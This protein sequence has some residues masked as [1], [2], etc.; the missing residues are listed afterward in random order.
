MDSR[1]LELLFEKGKQKGFQEQEIYYVRNKSTDISVYDGAIDKY[2][3]SE[4]SGLSYR[5]MLDGKLGYAYS[6]IIDE[7]AIEMLVLE[8][9]DNARVI[10]SDDEVFLF[11]G[12]E[13]YPEINHY[14]EQLSQS[15]ISEKI[16]FMLSLERELKAY[17]P[18]IKSISY[19]QYNESESFRRIKNTKGLDVTELSNICYA[20]AM[21]VVSDGVDTRTGLGYD[22]SNDFY[23]LSQAKI[24]KQAAEEAL[25]MLGA[26]TVKSKTCPVVIKNGT[27]AEFFSAFID[28]YNA[29]HVQKD[30]S[31]MAGR[32]GDQVSTSVLTVVDDP[33]LEMGLASSSFDAEGVATQKNTLIE[34]GVL[35]TFFHN[36]KTANKDGV[37]STGNASKASYKGTVGISPSNLIVKPG[38]ISFDEMISDIGEGVYVTSLQGMHAG[39]DPISG[40]FS[41]QCHGYEISGGKLGKPVSQI[42][43][44]GNYFELLN[45]IEAFSSDFEFSIMA[46]PYTGSA[47]VKIKKLAISGE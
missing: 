17:D 15:P 42:T 29:E 10:E 12:S 43:V 3:L 14:N 47:S 39:L 37:E 25:S 21:I 13:S 32:L 27:F 26:K 19:N 23:Q 30:L 11:K 44:A 9:Y 22:I 6:E 40:D 46:E 34:E 28:V 24:I 16:E 31:Q 7:K 41:L 18:R 1:L 35:K 36:L 4:N 8:A 33:H 38:T 20:Y 45:D 2:N 5:A